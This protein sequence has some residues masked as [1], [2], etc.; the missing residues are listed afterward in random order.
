[1]SIER[2]EQIIENPSPN[3]LKNIR[4]N[5][6]AREGHFRVVPLAVPYVVWELLT[7]HC[8]LNF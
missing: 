5:L 1:M 3:S 7:N 6:R 2:D 4:R 8:S